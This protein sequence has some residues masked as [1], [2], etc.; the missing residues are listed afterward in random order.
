M[1][2]EYMPSVTFPYSEETI[3]VQLLGDTGEVRQVLYGPDIDSALA[4]MDVLFYDRFAEKR[5]S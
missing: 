5:K 3:I 4:D 1:A 2:P